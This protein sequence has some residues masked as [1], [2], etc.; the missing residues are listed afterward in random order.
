MAIRLVL[1]TLLFLGQILYGGHSVAFHRGLW[2]RAMSI[3]SPDSL[4]KIISLAEHL[5]IT[6]LYVQVVVGGY[7][8]YKSG[9]LPRSEYLAKNSTTD[10]DPLDSLLKMGREKNIKVHAWVNT[11]LIWSMDSLPDSVRHVHHR[12]PDWFLKDVSGRSMLDYSPVMRQ[13]LGVEGTFLNPANSG[14]I[15][16]LKDICVE[17]VRKYNIDGIHLDFIRFP[18]VFWGIE[19]SLTAALISGLNNQDLR[20]LT[21]PRYARL[22][23]FNRWI[24]Y[25]L[26]LENKNRELV[27]AELVKHIRVAVRSISKDCIL[28]CAVVSNP[29]RAL[30][31]YAQNWCEWKEIVDYPVVMSYT[32]DVQLFQDFLNYAMYFIPSSI[33]GVGFLWKNMEMQANTEI[34]FVRKANAK[35]FCYF[36]FAS[37][38]TM[39]DLNMLTDTAMVLPESICY[40]PQ[41]SKSE[42]TDSIFGEKALE[43]WINQGEKYIKYG[44]DLDFAQYLL[45]LSLTPEQ[46]IRKMGIDREEFLKNVKQDV[47][48]FE[49]LNHT[50][51]ST[52]D[53]LIEPPRRDIEYTFVRWNTDSNAVRNF[54]KSIAKLDLKETIYPEAMNPVARAVF[55]AKI[56]EKKIIETRSGIYVFKVRR[57]KEGNK[58]VRKKDIREDLLP[59]YTYWTIRRKLEKKYYGK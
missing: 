25:N 19:N 40:T 7:S 59:I 43:E 22:S 39:A 8:Y 44:E 5:K 4:P 27:I 2:V 47:A 26:Y 14:V 9:I 55:E 35:G 24:V 56:G 17:I 10:Y 51:L 45:S 46:H 36:D 49:Y 37:L 50:L 1:G 23:L 16:Y 41:V 12:H 18:G 57:I 20:W 21:L 54:A 6:D 52:Y 30:Y 31:Q 33:M 29:S 58:F 3:A 32:T 38:D 28:S 15:E 42:N 48:G 34:E 53:K 13:D 11:L